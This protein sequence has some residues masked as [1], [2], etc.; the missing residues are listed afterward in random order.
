M[1]PEVAEHE[2]PPSLP[3][4]RWELGPRD[5]EYD[6]M[7]GTRYRSTSNGGW[8]PAPEPRLPEPRRG[9]LPALVRTRGVGGSTDAGSRGVKEACDGNDSRRLRTLGGRSH[10]P[11]RSG[12]PP[13]LD[14][15]R[16]DDEGVGVGCRRASLVGLLAFDRNRGGPLGWRPAG[17]AWA[18][19]PVATREPRMAGD[20]GGSA[21][22]RRP[23]SRS[24]PRDA[25]RGVPTGGATAWLVRALV[26]DGYS[27]TTF[28]WTGVAVLGL[29]VVIVGAGA[30]GAV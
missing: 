28:M 7:T 15:R 26:G 17:P 14:P 20:L 8:G 9:G 29:A 21:S 3:R 4:P 16:R 23:R 18:G 2:P 13:P 11:C 24:L 25:R 12:R 19:F 6:S 10:R 22:G 30:A 1:D 5:R 27:A